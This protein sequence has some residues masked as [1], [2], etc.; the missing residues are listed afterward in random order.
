[1]KTNR[2][3]QITFKTG[4][5]TDNG[6][7]AIALGFMRAENLAALG[8]VPE[9]GEIDEAFLVV[10]ESSSV[11]QQITAEAPY[12]P[13]ENWRYM[14]Y[15]GQT[16]ADCATKLR[17]MEVTGEF[18]SGDQD[19]IVALELLGMLSAALKGATTDD[20][21][22]IAPHGEMTH[23]VIIP[24][25]GMPFNLT[26]LGIHNARFV[27]GGHGIIALNT[28][29]DFVYLADLGEYRDRDAWTVINLEL[30]GE[31]G[32][33]NFGDADSDACNYV[34]RPRIVATGE[35]ATVN[36][37]VYADGKTVQVEF[38]L[39]SDTG[40][41]TAITGEDG[42]RVVGTSALFANAEGRGD[43]HVAFTTDR[44]GAYGIKATPRAA[45]TA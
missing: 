13:R 31:D 18:D 21:F 28:D 15:A 45:A 4:K 32:V 29:G 35:N 22:L 36:V 26:A 19:D 38:G 3:G 30:E 43:V 44:T 16:P 40:K 41:I 2:T 20:L 27:E 14:A 9:G 25:S 24:E 34:G 39:E 6:A 8:W 42:E 10:C 17:L 1:M 37:A 33:Y 23:S 7:L 11:G 5:F 12:K